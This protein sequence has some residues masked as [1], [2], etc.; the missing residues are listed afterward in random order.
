MADYITLFRTENDVKKFA[1]K[2]ECTPENILDMLASAVLV[3]LRDAPYPG[4][5]IAHVTDGEEDMEYV[6][7][8]RNNIIDVYRH[9]LHA[10]R[11]NAWDI[12]EI[13]EPDR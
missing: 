6:L 10:D 1:K 4:V 7:L 11:M 9:V 12:P 13:E 2:I 5:I 3:Y 8:L